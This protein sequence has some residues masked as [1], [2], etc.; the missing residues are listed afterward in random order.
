MS[1]GGNPVR[2]TL[3]A[4]ELHARVGVPRSSGSPCPPPISPSMWHPKMINDIS[5]ILAH[6]GNQ[7]N[8]QNGPNITNNVSKCVFGK[9]HLPRHACFHIVLP[10]VCPHAPKKSIKHGI[11]LTP[12]LMLAVVAAHRHDEQIHSEHNPKM[13]PTPDQNTSIR[14]KQNNVCWTCVCN[15]WGPTCSQNCPN[16]D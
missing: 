7:H 13:H 4:R 3:P 1:F 6:F 10:C 11:I 9:L 14:K 5:V 15:H 2:S 12:R 16:A 8:P